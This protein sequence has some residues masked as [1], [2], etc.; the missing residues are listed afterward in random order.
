MKKLFLL[1]ISTCLLFGSFCL[2]VDKSK[3][4]FFFHRHFFAYDLSTYKYD[5]KK[6]QF[7]IDLHY[8]I[9]EI[10]LIKLCQFNDSYAQFIILDTNYNNNTKNLE[11]KYKGF[12][13]G[14]YVKQKDNKTKFTNAKFYYNDNIEVSDCKEYVEGLINDFSNPQSYEYKYYKEA[15]EIIKEYKEG[16]LKNLNQVHPLVF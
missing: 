7:S 3:T 11:A 9:S 16:K 8:D 14:T 4:D 6:E 1:I 2:A 12:V 5:S 10:P 13:L 15:I